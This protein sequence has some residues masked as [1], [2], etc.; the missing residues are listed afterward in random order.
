ME[1]QVKWRECLK[2]TYNWRA[3]ECE[4]SI[5]EAEFANFDENISIHEVPQ[6]GSFLDGRC[7]GPASRG[8]NLEIIMLEMFKPCCLN[9]QRSLWFVDIRRKVEQVGRLWRLPRFSHCLCPFCGG[10]VKPRRVLLSRMILCFGVLVSLP[11]LP[12][13]ALVV[14]L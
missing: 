2:C 4:P 7:S 11:S 14:L 9:C 8:I 5:S 6:A 13:A 1:N 10:A 12:S 3:L